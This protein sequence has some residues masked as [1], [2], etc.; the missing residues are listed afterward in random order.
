MRLITAILLSS[1]MH[2]CA[3]F[4]SEFQNGGNLNITNINSINGK[5]EIV[6][7]QVDT[8]KRRFISG[9]L[10][11]NLI[12]EFER[13]PFSAVYVNYDEDSTNYIVEFEIKNSK[14]IEI[15]FLNNDQVYNSKI[16]KYKLKKDGFLYLKNDNTKSW[17][18]PYLFGV[19]D[20]NKNRI[21][22]NEE[23]NLVLDVA[24]FRGGAMLLIAF[25]DG[26]RTYYRKVIRKVN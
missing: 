17:G 12:Q 25:L 13:N 6:P 24:N 16:L 14:D 8:T 19:M 1:I 23:S 4:S 3:T 22:V 7:I 21:S 15:K 2:S 18:V 11:Y 10:N 20:I 9:R 5:Y 26:G